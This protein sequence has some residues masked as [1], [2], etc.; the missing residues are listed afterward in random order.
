VNPAKNRTFGG[1]FHDNF[2]HHLSAT[3]HHLLWPSFELCRQISVYPRQDPLNGR[4]EPLPPV[5]GARWG[6]LLIRPEAPTG[7]CAGGSPCSKG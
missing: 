6:L 7:P 2:V 5:V 4:Q 1:I 3:P